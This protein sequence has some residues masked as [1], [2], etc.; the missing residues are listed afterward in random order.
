MI[1]EFDDEP[2]IEDL[3]KPPPLPAPGERPPDPP[4]TPTKRGRP[5]PKTA[6][7]EAVPGVDIAG[8]WTEELGGEV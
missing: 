8:D 1:D 5:K 2:S 6:W 3:V 7:R 4:P